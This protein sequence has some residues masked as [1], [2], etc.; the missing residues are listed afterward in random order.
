[1]GCGCSKQAGF[2]DAENRKL[3]NVVHEDNTLGLTSPFHTAANLSGK[4]DPV[5][6]TA[7]T[8]DINL[9]TQLETIPS[10]LLVDFSESL[11]IK[12]DIIWNLDEEEI[13]TQH[14]YSTL[15]GIKETA[16]SELS[17]QNSILK[18]RISIFDTKKG[19]FPTTTGAF[20]PGNLMEA[21]VPKLQY[22]RFQK[23]RDN[24]VL[25]YTDMR[26]TEFADRP[27]VKHRPHMTFRSGILLISKLAKQPHPLGYLFVWDSKPG[28]ELSP[29]QISRFEELAVQA[30]TV[31]QKSL[32]KAIACDGA[33]DD[34]EQPK[35]G[36]NLEST[37]K[38]VELPAVWV[39][40]NTNDWKILGINKQWEMLTSVTLETIVNQSA[41]A[42]A[43]H[44][45]LLDI[46]GP[47]DGSPTSE[48]R[49]AIRAAAAEISPECSIPAILSP[50]S[51]A[52]SSLQ[53]GVAL[54]KA[55]SPPPILSPTTSDFKS[56][57]DMWMV[58]VHVRVQ[59]DTHDPSKCP[60]DAPE[61]VRLSWQ[62]AGS[63][64]SLGSSGSFNQGYLGHQELGG[65]IVRGSSNSTESTY[66]G[67]SSDYMSKVPSKAL[68][69]SIA[70]DI[71]SGIP[72]RLNTLRFGEIL[73]SGSYAD[74]YSGYLGSR[75]VAIK[76]IEIPD[77]RKQKK[78]WGA[79]YEAL[80]AVD[81]KHPNVITTYDWSRIE[82]PR[83]WQVW[84]I[85]ERC[86]GGSLS[87]AIESGS[88]NK[89]EDKIK[90]PQSVPDLPIILETM[91]EVAR[92]MRYLHAVGEV[93]ADLSSNNVLLTSAD[94]QRGFVAKVTDFGLSKL[95]TSSHVTESY[96]TVN[97]MPPEVLL[98]GVVSKAG[99]VYAFGVI[100]WEMVYGKRAWRGLSTTQVV[101]AVSCREQKLEMPSFEGVS[102]EVVAILEKCTATEASE[103]PTFEELCTELDALIDGGGTK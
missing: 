78:D 64:G 48:L 94:N 38:I 88:L 29:Q 101:F 59:A 1:M 31:L 19:W 99:D 65:L 53:Y 34:V 74:V 84:I 7:V 69:L 25:T 58:E 22:D 9:H 47:A 45:G 26:L 95:G 89:K 15:E 44:A 14:T 60:A 8:A 12:E 103:R 5:P 91:R 93:H 73:G 42:A 72:P 33:E 24:S 85:Q 98:E 54:I 43:E 76:V 55:T 57:C 66:R 75:P 56:E 50:R 40:L 82:E 100:F 13:A 4:F 35:D 97:Y 80:L 39:D 27:A 52:G 16:C 11:H 92:G 70:R 87:Q 77:T 41:A 30:V 21:S 49:H 71:L 83:G 81:V 62:S 86:D 18:G 32:K 51:P 61:S 17:P 67:P 68:S 23:I 20:S 63:G 102:K 6:A 37:T 79:H 10:S 46:M 36:R 28:K 96:G 2:G 90:N 3:N